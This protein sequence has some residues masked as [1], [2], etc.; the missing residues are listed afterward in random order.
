MGYIRVPIETNPQILVQDIFSYIQSKQPQWTPSDGNLDV[1]IIRAIADKAAENRIIASDVPDDIFGT[2]G[3]SLF[4]IPPGDEVSATGNTTWTLLDNLGHT[5]PAGIYIGIRDTNGDLHTFI[6]LNNVIVAPG[7]TTTAIG[8]VT[9]QAVDP[10]VDGNDLTGTVEL[11]TVIDWVVSVAIVGSTAGGA[12]A[13]TM[14]T[15]LNRLTRKLQSLSTVPILPADFANAALDAEAGAFR[16][17]AIDLYNPVHNLLTANQASV[18]TDASGWAVMQNCALAQGATGLDGLSSLRITASAADAAAM[19]T[20]N[21]EFPVAPGRF[22]TGI[23][24]AKANSTVRNVRVGIRWLDNAFATLS[25]T[26][27]SSV[28]DITTGWTAVSVTGNA[29]QGAAYARLMVQALAT[30]NTEIH[31]FDKMSLRHGSGTDWVAGGTSEANNIKNITIAAVDIAGNP[32][33]SFSKS[34]ILSYINARREANWV[35]H[36]TDAK[37]TVMDAAASIKVLPGY[38]P[39]ATTALV[40]SALASYFDPSNWAI[41]PLASTTDA[42]TTWIDQNTV[43]YNEVIALIILPVLH[44][45]ALSRRWQYNG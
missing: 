37:Y 13:E 41:D 32:I 7:D 38:D 45:L 20:P 29:P 44:W 17:V 1:W 39:T 14:P 9:I 5:I 27:G 21:N 36:V 30:V 8:E 23:A 26:W 31:F 40:I 16:A 6:T 18:E 11:I 25:D 15:Y 34:A 19:T 43:Y 33:T 3:A 4:A 35:T 24:S 2:M 10:G 12:D 28:A 42:P 22:Y